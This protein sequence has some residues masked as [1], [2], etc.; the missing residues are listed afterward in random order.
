MK[1]KNT[2][3]MLLLLLVILPATLIF[4]SRMPGRWYYFT[5]TL[6]ILETLASF[7]LIFEHRNP[8]ARELV[9]LA[10]LCALAAASR[11]AFIMV[12]FFKPMSA[13][14]MMAGISFGPIAGFLV[15]AVSAF[16]S[17]FIFGQGPW[18]PW[19]MFA[20]GFA[21]FLAG[22]LCQKGWLKKDR[23]TLA[24][25]GFVS[26]VAVIGPLLD[27]STLLTMST[28]ISCAIAGGIYLAGLPVNMVHGACTAL[29]LYFFA[30]PMFEKLDRVK[31]KYG[32]LED[33]DGI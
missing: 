6:M 13:I 29:T 32:M 20:Y 25:F 17:N 12:D 26:V 28:T 19:Q 4:G 8:Q 23:K 5:S 21:G 10:V 18:T 31:E 7:F 15:G 1:K 27:S 22:G 33:D 16:A 9:V 3:M 2:V 11:A 24:V 14:I 30:E